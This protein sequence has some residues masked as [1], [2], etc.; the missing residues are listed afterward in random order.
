MEKYDFFKV[1]DGNDADSVDDAIGQTVWWLKVDDPDTTDVDEDSALAMGFSAA[2]FHLDDWY[3]A[4]GTTKGAKPLQ[5]EFEVIREPGIPIDAQG[6]VFAFDDSV[7]ANNAPKTAYWDSSE[8]D[9]NALPLYPGD[10]HHFQWAFTKAGTYV[11][12]VQLKGHVR[13]KDDPRRAEA[14]ADWKP[15]SPETV[16]TSEVRQ[17]VFQIG[18]LTLNHD[19]VFEVERPVE[20]NSAAGALVGGPVGVYHEDPPEKEDTDTLTYTLS[21]PGDTL[22]DVEADADGNAQL[23]VADGAVLDYEVRSEYRLLLGIS[24][25]KDHENNDDESVDHTI[26]VRIDVTDQPE[27]ERSVQENSAADTLVGAPIEVTDAGTNTLAYTLS[28]DGHDLFTVER[29]ATTGNAQIKVSD[30]GGL[31]YE[32]RSSY[33]LDLD[34]IGYAD[35]S[36][37]HTVRVTITVTDQP[38]A[39]R[40]VQENS[41]ADAL[42]DAPIEVTDAGTNTLAYTLSGGGHG[43]FTVERDATTGNAQIKV[44]DQAGLDYEVRSSYHLDLGVTG[45]A[46]TS[47]DHTV[48]VT[49]TVTDVTETAVVET[50]DD[51]L[52]AGIVLTAS[53]TGPLTASSSGTTVRLTASVGDLPAGYTLDGF[54]W[55]E[56]S[57]WTPTATTWD[58]HNAHKNHRPHHSYTKSQAGTHRF[59]VLI[60]YSDGHGTRNAASNLVEVEWR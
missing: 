10:Y 54:A 39:E 49:I 28:G 4:D 58:T 26:S 37:D 31:D 25:G 51:S 1:G 52:A 59:R 22:F 13:T 34:V 5:Y 46:D 16:V 21:G 9:A 45:Y 44:S 50:T 56:A 19:P 55:E 42:V 36:N 12:S 27:A 20:E 15:I 40:S 35:T 33:Q 47:N 3:L 23:T 41:A 53:P 24:D 29:D 14:A 48:R 43:H 2:L 18:P 17:Y 7:P 6:H 11:I 8:V 60:A 38:E 57:S 30:Q 32:V